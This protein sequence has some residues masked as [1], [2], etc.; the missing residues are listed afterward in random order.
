M[1]TT[2]ID[3]HKVGVNP[4]SVLPM[5]GSSDLVVLDAANS[6]FYTV[7]LPVSQGSV[8]K[9]LAGDKVGYSD[10]E[11][12]SAQ[13]NRPRSF[14]IDLRGNVYVADKKNNV[15]RKITNSGVK[16]IA[17][18]YEN[19]GRQD[20][21]AQNASFSSDFELSFIPQSC[22]LLISDHGNQL[23][24]QIVLKEEDCRKGSPSVMGAAWI[25]VLGLGL[26]GFLG[27]IVGVVIRPYIS[28]L[29][30]TGR[31]QPPLFQRD[32][33]ALPNQSGEASTDSLLRRQKRNC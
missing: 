4:H 21:P 3:G 28:F 22:S 19:T 8:P 26:S 10:G 9:H 29:S 25:W 5:Y 15:I 16:T 20:G 1:V 17:G 12:S 23:V 31:I 11:L 24:R 30:H 33:E 7:S 6:A 13:F 14:A 32:M 18:G 27:L 2:V